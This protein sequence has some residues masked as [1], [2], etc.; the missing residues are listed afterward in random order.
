MDVHTFLMMGRPGSGKGTQAK[1]L[2]KKLGGDIYS[3]GNRLREMAKGQG[4]VA[5]KVKSVID[6]GG[7]LPEW[8]S[9]HLFVD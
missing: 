5:R 6:A 8:F 9:S 4:F 2:A 1:L 7:L 3:S